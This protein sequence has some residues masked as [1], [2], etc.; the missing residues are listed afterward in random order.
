MFKIS[1]LTPYTDKTLTAPGE[2]QKQLESIRQNGY[3]MTSGEFH[4]GIRFRCRRSLIGPEKYWL[5]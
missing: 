1:N 4:P 5:P 2:F 3:S